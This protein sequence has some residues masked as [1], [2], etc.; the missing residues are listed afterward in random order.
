MLN[1]VLDHEWLL[2][3]QAQAR[4]RR[5]GRCLVEHVEV[6]D[7]ELLLDGVGNLNSCLLVTA[8]TIVGA[9]ADGARA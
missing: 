7:G 4:V 9:K 2:L 5:Q 8:G 1:F 3:V 6:A